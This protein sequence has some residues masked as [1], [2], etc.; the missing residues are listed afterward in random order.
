MW[1]AVGGLLAI[2][3]GARLAYPSLILRRSA[4]RLP[5]GSDGV[6]KGAASIERPREKAPAVLLLHG[7][8]DTPQVMAGL[9]D[10]LYDAGFA[11]RVP[12]LSGHGRSLAAFSK[13]DAAS[14]HEEV[15][16]EYERLRSRHDWVAV[17]GLSMGGALAIALAAE[18][19]DIPALVLL[20]PYVAMSP[21]LR[22]L[23]GTSGIWGAVLPY[24]SSGGARSI[25]DPEA[26]A[27]G[28]A[29]G[30]FTPRALRALRDV[31]VDAERTLPSIQAPTLM[32]QSLND[33]RIPPQAARH[34][35]ESIGA[36]DKR[37]E[38]LE[39]TGHVIT[40]DHGKEAVFD[41]VSDW[42]RGQRSSLRE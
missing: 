38:W 39:G 7:G 13:V 27:K 32:I 31:V 41:L 28:L 42:L 11:V 3:L 9:A 4:R 29:Y 33:N 26:A 20:S 10:Y 40:V 6:V 16:A 15:R 22:R 5:V 35:F 25:H 19:D 18:R 24:F 34:I 1:A 8:G 23:A 12:L 36:S 14:W 30:V 21:L 2:A 17:V 37:I